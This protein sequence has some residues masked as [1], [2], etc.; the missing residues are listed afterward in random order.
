MNGHPEDRPLQALRWSDQIYVDPILPFGRCSAPK[1]FNAVA[2]ALHWYLGH[3]G[4]THLFHY[5]ND[6]IILAPPRSPCCQQDLSTLLEVCGELGVPIAG[7]KTEG[8]AT[9][10]VFLGI[11]VDTVANELRLP[12]DKLLRLQAL[13]EQW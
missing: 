12:G 5:L 13:Q 4:I 11:E 6:F 7:H 8:P 9:C 1:V 10:L 2:D 3:T